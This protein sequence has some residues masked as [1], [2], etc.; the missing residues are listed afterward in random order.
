[1]TMK[2]RTIR[3]A[4]RAALLLLGSVIA[5][6]PLAAAPPSQ[7]SCAVETL[8]PADRA[9]ITRMLTTRTGDLAA[10]RRAGSEAVSRCAVRFGW[11]KGQ[12]DAAMG[13]MA[14][15]LMQAHHRATLAGAGIDVAW[16]E[17]EVAADA[18]L[19]ASSAPLDGDTPA[20]HAF[21][22]R[23]LSRIDA[24][25]RSDA[26]VAEA[27]GAFVFSTAFLLNEERRFAAG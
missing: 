9:A 1:M 20:F 12:A 4:M 14:A 26:A 27:V 13:H 11:S 15:S 22:R 8:S 21:S 17:R 19:I 3:G 5:G 25:H 23:V 18:E 6:S 2:K 7:L 10:T 16:L 24:R